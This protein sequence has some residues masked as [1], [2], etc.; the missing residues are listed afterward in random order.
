MRKRS[1]KRRSFGYRFGT[2]LSNMLHC[3]IKHNGNLQLKLND[4]LHS[5]VPVSKIQDI[6]IGDTVIGKGTFGIVREGTLTIIEEKTVRKG[7]SL[8]TIK[9]PK[10]I[11]CVVK[12][13]TFE[14]NQKNDVF[15]ETDIGIVLGSSG[16]GP[17]V[18]YAFYRDLPSYKEYRAYIIMEKMN[19]PCDKLIETYKDCPGN[20]QQVIDRMIYIYEKLI[21]DYNIYCSDIKPPNFLYKIEN[22]DDI[23]IKMSDFGG[24]YC[25]INGNP[26]EI[27][28]IYWRTQD[29]KEAKKIYK[30]VCFMTGVFS[31]LVNTKIID[32]AFNYDFTNKK[33]NDGLK[34]LDY[35]F[36]F[37]SFRNDFNLSLYHYANI[38][39]HENLRDVL[40]SVFP[41]YFLFD[42]Y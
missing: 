29:L 42:S 16:F 28:Q 14:E 40:L 21:F 2:R 25:K 35:F 11:D 22:N 19:G 4:I 10:T 41:Q 3:N 34:Y 38:K 30:Y 31:L 27:Q 23:T 9:T 32:P 24:E 12:I 33:M 15:A 18:Y 37:I 20:T 5:C 6:Q 7:R 8:E 17:K 13:M 39:S 26:D 36:N 1:L